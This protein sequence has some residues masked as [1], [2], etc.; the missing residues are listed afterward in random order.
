MPI[1]ARRFLRK[2]RGGSQ[3]HLLEADDGHCYVVKF[4]NNPQ[5]RRI[6]VNEWLA[7]VFLRYLQVSTPAV[8]IIELTPEFLAAEPGVHFAVG[9]QRLAVEPGLHFGSRYPGHPDAV[10]VF[11]FVPDQQLAH[12]LNRHDFLGALV[13]DKWVSNA[14]ARQAIFYLTRVMAAP[15]AVVSSQDGL[16]TMMVDNGFVF[17]GP[18]WRFA[19]SPIQGQYFRPLVYETVRGLES[20]EPWLTRVLHFPEDI[21]DEARR[22]IPRPWVDDGIA[23]DGLL[24]RLWRRRSQVLGLLEACR[25][26]R[27]AAFPNWR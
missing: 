27:G 21:L 11:D 4:V 3:A 6:L 12:C 2:M 1:R 5:H 9:P 25:G 13:F 23:L 8:A 22:Q 7:S 26:A 10:S 19:D 18:N 16:V 20:F 15:G 14:D 24:E 17:D